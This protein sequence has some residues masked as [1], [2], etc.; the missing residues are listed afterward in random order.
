MVKT[1]AAALHYSRILNKL[2]LQYND[3]DQCGDNIIVE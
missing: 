2:V 1:A 3:A